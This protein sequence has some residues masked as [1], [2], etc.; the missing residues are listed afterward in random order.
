MGVQ[1]VSR[2]QYDSTMQALVHVHERDHAP[3][4]QEDG[5]VTLRSFHAEHEHSS[6]RRTKGVI[7]LA[8]SFL[9]IFSALNAIFYSLHAHDYRHHCTTAHLHVLCMRSV[10]ILKSCI[11]VAVV[12]QGGLREGATDADTVL[13]QRKHPGVED[14]VRGGKPGEAE[15]EE[16]REKGS[17]K[18]PLMWFGILVP[19]HLRKCQQ[20]FIKGTHAAPAAAAVALADSSTSLQPHTVMRSRG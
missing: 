17:H 19:D 14:V 15:V 8:D 11:S 13:R 20:D 5:C 18:D 4:E 6:G 3:S 16:D 9:S 2:L 12:T 10:L 1:A 7:A